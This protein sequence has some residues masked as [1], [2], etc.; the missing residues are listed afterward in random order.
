MEVLNV[1][2]IYQTLFI[3]ILFV[4]SYAI[5]SREKNRKYI[6]SNRIVN[7]NAQ[8]D[9]HYPWMAFLVIETLTKN[10]EKIKAST[11]TGSIIM[12]NLIITAAHCIC[13]YSEDI[14]EEDSPAS[15]CKPHG[16][17]NKPVNQLGNG[18]NIYYVIGHKKVDW[19]TSKEKKKALKGFV[20]EAEIADDGKVTRGKYF[21][22][23]GLIMV[24]IT[25]DEFKNPNV[26]VISL[27][28][29]RYT[30]HGKPYTANLE[31]ELVHIAGWGRRFYFGYTKL[32]DSYTIGTFD[33]P[34]IHSSCMTNE[35]GPVGSRF[36]YCDTKKVIGSNGCH[37]NDYPAWDLD[38]HDKQSCIRYWGDAETLLKHE[39][40]PVQEQFKKATRIKVRDKICYKEELLTK[41]GW[42]E[43]APSELALGFLP[44]RWGFCSTSCNIDFMKNPKPLEYQVAQF[45]VYDTQQNKI[46][47]CEWEDCAQYV[48]CKSC[49][50]T[51]LIPVET[52]TW[53]F[54]TDDKNQ[55]VL[56]KDTNPIFDDS[57]KHRFSYSGTGKGD[58]GGPVWIGG[59]RKPEVLVAIV[60]GDKGKIRRGRLEPKSPR[61]SGISVKIT[62]PIIKWI[63]D[64]GI[65]G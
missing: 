64:V 59:G 36:R 19:R 65:C 61:P 49:I 21:I 6:A 54:S 14:E 37:K 62:S 25:A 51:R 47:V 34:S 8:N 43:L 29:L 26:G 31:N 3:V 1:V 42:C 22:D 58:S 35:Y 2:L 57:I 55:L 28:T 11:C 27:P 52:K 18:N 41:H 9:K 17:D 45:R 32:G 50:C 33:K 15:F 5:S 4:T 48:K 16:P 10:E 60:S 53:I 63:R 38:I 23:I 7:P 13:I 46:N 40:I 12:S 39:D 24:R 30:V 44:T 20:Y 56:S